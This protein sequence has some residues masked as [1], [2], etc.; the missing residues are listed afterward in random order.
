MSGVDSCIRVLNTAVGSGRGAG[1]M[2]FPR[3]KAWCVSKGIHAL[4]LNAPVLD[5]SVNE[6]L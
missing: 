4:C 5:E 3:C 1:S 6:L 2:V